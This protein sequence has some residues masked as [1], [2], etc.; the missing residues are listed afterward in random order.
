MLGVR[1][2]GLLVG[3]NLLIRDFL[4]LLTNLDFPLFLMGNLLVYLECEKY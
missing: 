1:L 2:I 4:C 3:D